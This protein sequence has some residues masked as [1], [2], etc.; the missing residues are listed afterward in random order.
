M[1]KFIAVIVAVILFVTVRTSYADCTKPAVLSSAQKAQAAQAWVSQDGAPEY[2]VLIDQVR[3]KLLAMQNPEAW[4]VGNAVG[5]GPVNTIDVSY[6]RFPGSQ[7]RNFTQKFTVVVRSDECFDVLTLGRDTSAKERLS[8]EESKVKTTT[9][10]KSTEEDGSQTPYDFSVLQS[11][12]YALVVSKDLRY[13]SMLVCAHYDYVSAEEVENSLCFSQLGDRQT[14]E[15]IIQG[16]L[17]SK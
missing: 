4:Q 12:R 3:A 16:I 11:E 6:V 5:V 1:K 15:R 17:A 13:V 9:S 2:K 8:E 7:I 14:L 10:E